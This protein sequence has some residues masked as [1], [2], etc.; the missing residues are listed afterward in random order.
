M[1][2]IANHL[3]QAARLRTLVAIGRARMSA[4]ASD[5]FTNQPEQEITDMQPE[6]YP[7]PAPDDQARALAAELLQSVALNA[8]GQPFDDDDAASWDEADNTEP[9]VVRLGSVRFRVIEGDPAALATACGAIEEGAPPTLALLVE[10][11]DDEGAPQPTT[12]QYLNIATDEPGVSALFRVWTTSADLH[13]PS[14][15][16]FG[17]DAVRNEALAAIDDH[18]NRG[19]LVQ[20]FGEEEEAPE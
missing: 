10:F 2:D 17:P 5:S 13:D 3:E 1:P 4:R 9:E 20:V 6:T 19:L 18:P 14:A 15:P 12:G 7:E 11:A 16:N 8:D